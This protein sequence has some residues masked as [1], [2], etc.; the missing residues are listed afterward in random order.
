M[1]AKDDALSFGVSY[2][3]SNLGTLCKVFRESLPTIAKYE[4]VPRLLVLK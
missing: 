2:L 4:E 1:L 3:H